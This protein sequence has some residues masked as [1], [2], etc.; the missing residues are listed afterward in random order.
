MQSAT[1]YKNYINIIGA[2]FVNPFSK[3]TFKRY[4][5]EIQDT[6]F[7]GNDT[8]FGISFRPLMNTKF[9]G[10]TGKAYINTDRYAIQSITA[11]ADMKKIPGIGN[12]NTSINTTANQMTIS[13]GGDKKSNLDKIDSVMAI[14]I[15]HSYERDSANRWFPKHSKETADMV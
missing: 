9:M 12:L 10:L 7:D 13:A 11:T 8:I 5:F 15:K 2:R 1:F 3:G 14:R 6:I 4:Y